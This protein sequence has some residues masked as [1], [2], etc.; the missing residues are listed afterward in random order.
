MHKKIKL[1]LCEDRTEWIKVF[2]EEICKDSRFIY[3]G[4]AAT[5]DACI[6]MACSLTPDVV[7]MDIFLDELSDRECG[8]EAA[9]GIRINTESKIVFFTADDDDNL[10]REACKIGFASGYIRKAD[11]RTY[12]DEIYNAVTRSIPLKEGIIDNVKNQLT[13]AENDIL[14]KLIYGSIVENNDMNGMYG[15]KYISKCKTSIY[16]K[17]GLNKLSDREKSQVLIKI[18]KSW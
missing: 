3:L 2:E 6:N 13:I 17:L 18:F 9:K 11:Y 1:I 7:V 15:T 8:I 12:G 4:H 5:K 10:R 16:K 14:T